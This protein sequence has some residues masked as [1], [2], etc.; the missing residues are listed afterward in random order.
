MVKN[1]LEFIY[2]SLFS[3]ILC[4][5]ESVLESRYLDHHSH[6]RPEVAIVKNLVLTFWVQSFLPGFVTKK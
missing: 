2:L 5:L 6:F 3:C 1:L 4:L